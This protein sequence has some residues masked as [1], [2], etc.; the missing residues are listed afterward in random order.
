MTERGTD[1]ASDRLRPMA[2]ASPPSVFTISVAF[3]LLVSVPGSHSSDA[4]ELA[5]CRPL[6]L[7]LAPC[8]PFVQGSMPAPVRS[9]CNN[10]NDLVTQQPECLCLLLNN[11]FSLPVNQ[12]QALRL[13]QL[14]N[15]K[16]DPSSCPG[17]P[18]LPPMATPGPRSVLAPTEN[19]S[20]T[21]PPVMGLVTKSP[22]LSSS[23]RVKTESAWVVAAAAA[24]LLIT[25]FILGGRT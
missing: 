4:T 25:I 21:A 19:S 1:E 18:D 8:V 2:M 12:T 6:L 17:L 5:D 23:E 16:A 22:F 20:T 9:C 7:L 10:L 24:P 15:L 11:T 14:C 3:T 13:P